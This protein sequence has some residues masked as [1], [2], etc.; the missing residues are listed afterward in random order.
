MIRT[1]GREWLNFDFSPPGYVN[2]VLVQSSD[3]LKPL[4]IVIDAYWLKQLHCIRKPFDKIIADD[5]SLP[6][7]HLFK[8]QLRSLSNLR[9]YVIVKF[10][11]V[12]LT[13]DHFTLNLVLC[14]PFST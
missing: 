7:V 8:L 13:L 3:L 10:H 12:L 9:V 11:A 14:P 2:T 6:S 5:S 4:T 1:F